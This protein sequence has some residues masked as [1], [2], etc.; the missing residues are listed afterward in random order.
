MSDQNQLAVLF[1]DVTGS[2]SLYHRLGNTVAKRLVDD[3]LQR[4]V[5]ITQDFDGVLIK[6]IGDEVMCTFTDVS[7]AARAAGEMQMAVKKMGEQADDADTR[8][9]IQIGFHFGRVIVDDNDVF[10]DTVNVAARMAGMAKPEQI[11]LTRSVVNALPDILRPTVRFYDQATVRGKLEHLEI[12]ELIWEVSEMTMLSDQKV[13]MPRPEMHS[14]LDLRCGERE[15]RLDKSVR[16][17]SLG[18]SEFNGLQVANSLASRQHAL[19]EFRRGRFVLIDQSV[20]GT[21]LQTAEGDRLMLKREEYVLPDSGRFSL[22]EELDVRPETEVI[23]N[24][25]HAAL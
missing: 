2:T 6:T 20:N 10:G 22:G 16:N 14:A 23:F 18:R 12:Y 7:N 5:E 3:H 11:L 9:R 17:L 21:Y 15:L 13:A 4:L 24:C 25:Q 8:L 1:A 19:I